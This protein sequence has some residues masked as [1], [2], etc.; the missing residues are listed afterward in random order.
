MVTSRVTDTANSTIAEPRSP[1]QRP[2]ILARFATATPPLHN[3][4]NVP[5]EDSLF[6]LTLA[7]A[8]S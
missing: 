7:I 1:R 5:P 3:W 4:K 6:D 8:P 2:K